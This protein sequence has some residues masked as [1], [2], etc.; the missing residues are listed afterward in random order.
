M[1]IKCPFCGDN[2]PIEDYYEH[3]ERC[4]KNKGKSEEEI[5]KYTKLAMYHKNT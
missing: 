3:F 4:R 2:L 1:K 5:E